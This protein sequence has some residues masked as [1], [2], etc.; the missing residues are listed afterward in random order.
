M[1]QWLYRYIF[2]G[3]GILF[4]I[5]IVTV[6]YLAISSHLREL[7]TKGAPGAHVARNR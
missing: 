6:L 4:V 5:G 3:T 7:E 1:I 2:R